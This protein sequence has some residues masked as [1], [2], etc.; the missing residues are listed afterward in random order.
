MAKAYDIKR[1]GELEEFLGIKI[2]RNLETGEVFVSQLDIIKDIIND[3]GEKVA[4]V[5]PIEAPMAKYETII[6]PEEGDL[7]V[8]AEE[9]KEYQSGVGKLMWLVQNTRPDLAN[10]VCELSKVLDGPTPGNYK[11]LLR[12]VKF[13]IVT[14]NKVL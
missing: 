3:F 7:W 14:K 13:T 1:L 5:K 10:S 2:V 9:H 6:R 11:S 4:N 12:V 8:N